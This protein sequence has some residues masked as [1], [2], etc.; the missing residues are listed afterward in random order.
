MGLSVPKGR[1]DLPL[2]IPFAVWIGVTVFYIALS[3]YLLNL[4]H[5]SFPVWLLIF[6]GLIWSPIN[7]YVSARMT[8]LTGNGVSVPYL[9]EVSIMRSGYPYVD[10]WYAPIPLN[11][12][13]G[14]AQKFREV[15]L[16]RTK[17]T[18]IVKVEFFMLPIM[19]SASFIF[20]AFFWHTSQ[21]PSSQFPFAAKFWPIRATMQAMFNTIN[22][23]H[24]G[25]Q[26]VHDAIN[27]PRIAGGVVAGLAIYGAF[28]MLRLPTLFF[29]GF[30]G[31]IGAF[32]HNTIASFIGAW[33][34]K[35]YFS[36]R[37]GVDNWRMYTPVLL[38]GFSC[39]TGL[40][41]MA[42]IALALIAKSVNYLPF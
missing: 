9:K 31:G 24:G 5:H 38:A 15:E 32:P 26:W 19:L 25:M 12:F 35:S 33:L 11:D 14:L 17:F 8:G 21:I 23:Q 28:F 29:Y 13:G 3:S 16:T 27:A 30:I 41:A 1:G 10:V 7:S 4:Q 42:S 40:V 18:S 34:G 2:W 22:K 6:Y 37:F 39:G 36:K 20:W